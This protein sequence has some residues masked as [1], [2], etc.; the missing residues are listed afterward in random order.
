[1]KVGE[2]QNTELQELLEDA[3]ATPEQAVTQHQLQQDL[4]TL[5]AE[6]SPIQREVITLRYGLSSGEPCSLSS[7]GEQLG[8]SRE[9]VRQ[10]QQSALKRLRLKQGDIYD[11]L[12]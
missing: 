3:D 4:L 9:R 6:L 5:L 7:V 1:M 11:Y 2:D 10:L 12:S 8:L